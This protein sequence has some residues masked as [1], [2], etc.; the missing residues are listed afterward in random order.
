[1][2]LIA[3]CVGNMAG[4]QVFRTEDAP[5]YVSGTVAC[6]ICFALETLLIILWRFYYMWENRRRD[7]IVAESGISKEEQVRLAKEM[8]DNNRTDREN[9]YFR[10]TM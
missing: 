2:S 9:I 1:M 6:S 7:R 10:Y 8:G 4:A 5:R 3:V